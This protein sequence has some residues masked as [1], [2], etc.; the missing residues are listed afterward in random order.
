MEDKE[1]LKRIRQIQ[2]I[3]PDEICAPVTD[4]ENVYALVE[5]ATVAETVLD[6]LDTMLTDLAKD[7]KEDIDEMEANRRRWEAED[8]KKRLAEKM[9]E[10][11]DV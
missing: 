8:A 5:R 6:I 3:V 11:A 9:Q 4:V 10:I 1:M 7:I 2:R